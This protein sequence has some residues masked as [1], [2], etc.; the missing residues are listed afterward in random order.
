M[1]EAVITAK[2]FIGSLA[3]IFICIIGSYAWMFKVAQSTDKKLSDIY[4]KMNEHHLDSD[5]HAKKSEFATAEGCR[6]TTKRIEGKLDDIQ[7]DVK[8]LLKKRV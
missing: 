1:I 2:V 7:S 4:D 3:S 5:V 8:E 6:L